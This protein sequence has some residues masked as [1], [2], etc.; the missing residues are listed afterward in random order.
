MALKLA[1]HDSPE[2]TVHSCS[3][4]RNFFWETS[5]DSSVRKLGGGVVRGEGVFP[6]FLR[7]FSAHNS[8][9]RTRQS[10]ATGA[11]HLPGGRVHDAAS[12]VCRHSAATA[13]LQCVMVHSEIVAQLMCQGHGSAK[14]AVWMVLK[15]NTRAQ[16]YSSHLL[17][18]FSLIFSFL[19][20]FPSLTL[21]LTEFPIRPSREPC[22]KLRTW[23]VIW[24]ISLNPFGGSPG[25]GCLMD[26]WEFFADLPSEKHQWER[27]K[28]IPND[29]KKRLPHQE[30]AEWK[31]RSNH[32][33]T[34]RL[35]PLWSF[36]LRRGRFWESFWQHTIIVDHVT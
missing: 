34:A 36:L 17:G 28:A 6:L 10:W 21:G 32:P 22:Y 18:L 2:H 15:G 11:W 14:G 30:D 23:E 29:R 31:M 7:C 20:V 35:N 9:L 16:I 1:A 24:P 8:K 13:P 4:C 19:G 25:E 12:F 3:L 33:W 5:I 26:M 27:Q